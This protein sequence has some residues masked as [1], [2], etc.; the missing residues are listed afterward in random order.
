MNVT[1]NRMLCLGYTTLKKRKYMIQKWENGSF[2]IFSIKESAI[3]HYTIACEEWLII[4]KADMCA[5]SRWK[6]TFF[7]AGDADFWNLFP[8]FE[9]LFWGLFP[10]PCFIGAF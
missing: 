2:S 1:N 3:W 6:P 5:L 8:G 9:R 10:F 4:H 7:A